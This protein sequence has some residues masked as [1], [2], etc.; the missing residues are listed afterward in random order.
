MKRSEIDSILLEY[1]SD[2]IDPERKSEYLFLTNKKTPLS[3]KTFWKNL[4]KVL[5]CCEPD[6]HVEYGPVAHCDRH[7]RQ[8][9]QALP[10]VLEC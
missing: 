5:T 8:N 10:L 3:R 9:A 2:K 7:R 6:G 4:K 1:I